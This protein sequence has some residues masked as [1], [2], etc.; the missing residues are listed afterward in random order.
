MFHTKAKIYEMKSEKL[1][2]TAEGSAVNRLEH[3]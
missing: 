1:N 3:G 2:S